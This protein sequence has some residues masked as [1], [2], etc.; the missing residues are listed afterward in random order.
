MTSSAAKIG[1]GASVE[2]LNQLL[3][4]DEEWLSSF[5][6]I[7]EKSATLTGSVCSLM[8]NF[9]ERIDSLSTNVQTLVAKSSV[10]QKEQQNI[11]KLLST[12]DATIQFHGKTTVLENTIRDGGNV[13]LNIDDYLEKM[14]N[15]KEAIAFFATHPVYRNHEHIKQIY[16]IGCANIESEFGNLVRTSCVPVDPTKVFEYLDDDYEMPS[17][18]LS[19]FVT[20]RDTQRIHKMAS[21]LL[22]NDDDAVCTNFLHFYAQYRAENMMK[23][24]RTIADQIGANNRSPKATFIKAREK[25]DQ[26]GP[27]NGSLNGGNKLSNAL[28]YGGRPINTVQQRAAVKLRWRGKNL[29]K[30]V[31]KLDE[32]TNDDDD[33][34]NDHP[35]KRETMRKGEKGKD[36][37]QK[38]S[39]DEIVEGKEKNASEKGEAVNKDQFATTV[40]RIFALKKVASRIADT[41]DQAHRDNAIVVVLFMCSTILVL[42]QVETN[43][44][45]TMFQNVKIEV[46]V[47]RQIVFDP[48]GRVLAQTQKVVDAYEGNFAALLPLIKFLVRHANQFAALS[49]N[50]GQRGLYNSLQSSLFSKCVQLI[51]LHIDRLSSGQIGGRFVPEDGNVHP[52]SSGTVNFLK[53]LVQHQKLLVQIFQRAIADEQMQ[54]QLLAGGINDQTNATTTATA[55]TPSMASSASKLFIQILMGLQKNL[56]QK[57]GAYSDLYLAG[58]FMF[59]NLGYIVQCCTKDKQLYAILQQHQP[60]L[61]STC[62]AEAE[63]FLQQYLESWGKIGALFAPPGNSDGWETSGEQQRK[64]VKAVFTAFNRDFDTIIE[65]QKHFC[66]ADKTAADDVRT[67]IKKIVLRPFIEFSTRNSRECSELFETDRQLKYDA[68]TIEMVI[69][70]LFY[71]TF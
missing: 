43:L 2:E 1:G 44:C 29:G 47:L 66:L 46:E 58:L 39:N 10:I 48:I 26:I 5:Q 69:D 27:N 62:E 45:S 36:G 4:K 68:E 37:R 49:E 54:Q 67:R 61:L 7:L 34:K 70:S 35:D 38:Q 55:S 63:K 11:R 23:P 28:R 6:G 22:D 64:A 21:W 3:S 51:R 65:S 40:F 42:I 53:L 71:A 59:N 41:A 56:Q 19:S 12:V 18:R 52:V 50:V 15:L 13:L 9:Q 60:K 16:E 31:E 17:F 8:D 14:R 32:E 30:I 20:L 24:L 25:P 33:Q 57:C